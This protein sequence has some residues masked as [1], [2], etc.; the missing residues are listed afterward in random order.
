MEYYKYDYWNW[1]NDAGRTNGIRGN[2]VPW[3][4][5][6]WQYSGY[7]VVGHKDL[8]SYTFTDPNG[9]GEDKQ[10]FK[11]CGTNAA[12]PDGWVPHPEAGELKLEQQF[13]DD[14]ELNHVAMFSTHGGVALCYTRCLDFYQ[15]KRD[16]ERWVKLHWKEDQGLGYGNLRHLFLATCSSMGWNHGPKH[17]EMANLAPDWMNEHVADGIRTICGADG[18]ATGAHMSGLK[19]FANYHK[20][21]SISQAWFNMALDECTCNMPVTVAYGSTEYE[22]TINLFDGRFTKDLA[23]TGWVI[24]A[25]LITEHFTTHRACCLAAGKC[26]DVTYEECKDPSFVKWYTGGEFEV[27]G[28]PI[29]ELG[30]QCG[31]FLPPTEIQGSN[32]K[33]YNCQQDNGRCP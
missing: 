1:W 19:F 6:S 31:T 14:L 11:H 29:M 33:R 2:W 30:S 4:L 27:A 13:Y 20:G 7:D 16:G 5:Q 12:F 18:P 22:A 32:P 9:H 10:S 21:E 23:G 15:F 8:S 24:A 25:E 26:I 3:P 28:T 17:G